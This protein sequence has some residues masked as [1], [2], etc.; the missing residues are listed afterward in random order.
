MTSEAIEVRCFEV[1]INRVIQ[2]CHP[3]KSQSHTHGADLLFVHG[4]PLRP[5]KVVNAH[6]INQNVV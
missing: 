3:K 4:Q 6:K 2:L 1:A 5:L